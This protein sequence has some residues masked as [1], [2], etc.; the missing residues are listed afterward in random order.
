MVQKVL[1][2]LESSFTHTVSFDCILKFFL[3]QSL[4]SASD[5]HGLKLNCCA[6]VRTAGDPNASSEMPE[7]CS[8]TFVHLLLLGLL[9]R[10]VKVCIAEPYHGSGDQ[11]QRD[12]GSGDNE[13]FSLI[14]I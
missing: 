5:L 7:L 10:A 13:A 4:T 9:P 1:L 12:T 6:S 2:L 14:E 3:L 11:F 8:T